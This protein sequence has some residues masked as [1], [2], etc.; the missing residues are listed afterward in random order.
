MHYI[1]PCH[2]HAFVSQEQQRIAQEIKDFEEKF[3]T[4]TVVYPSILVPHINAHVWAVFVLWR[5][6][7]QT[8]MARHSMVYSWL[9]GANDA[10]HAAWYSAW[11]SAEVAGANTVHVL[12]HVLWHVLCHALCC[13]SE[14]GAEK[15]Q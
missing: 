13:R 10:W 7:G 8:R 1:T 3:G 2:A 6:E 9:A 4:R 14:I 5:R 11:H 12:W 15:H